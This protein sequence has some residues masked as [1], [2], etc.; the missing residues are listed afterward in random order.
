MR[1]AKV[2]PHIHIAELYEIEA[3]VLKQTVRMNR[4]CFSDDFMYE[5]T[6]AEIEELVSLNAIPSKRYLSGAFQFAFTEKGVAMLANVL[7]GKRAID[8]INHYATIYYAQKDA[9]NTSRSLK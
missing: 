5:L 6:D 4:N 3:R 1:D 7:N 8:I 9:G 2:I